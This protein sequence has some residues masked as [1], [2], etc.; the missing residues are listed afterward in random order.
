MLLLPVTPIPA[1]TCLVA[2]HKHRPLVCGLSRTRATE[3]SQD[4]RE[5]Y[6]ERAGREESLVFPRARLPLQE[7]APTVVGNTWLLS[8]VSLKNNW[9]KR[10]DSHRKEKWYFHICVNSFSSKSGGLAQLV[11]P[12]TRCN[13]LKG[14]KIEHTLSMRG[15]GGSN[16]A[17]V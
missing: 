2:T 12:T 17:E 8:Q 3:S 1:L 5:K 16:L 10:D 6:L 7:L 4:K 15:V 14:S 9:D 13:N 11:Q